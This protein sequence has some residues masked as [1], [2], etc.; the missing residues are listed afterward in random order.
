M[1]KYDSEDKYEQS[2][3]NK[4]GQDGGQFTGNA[5]WIGATWYNGNGQNVG[6]YKPSCWPNCTGQNVGNA[7]GVGATWYNGN[8]QNVGHYKPSCWPNCTGQ[9]VGNAPGVGA[10]WYNGNGQNVGHYKPS[11]WPNCT[12]QN[13]G[14]AP[15]VGATWYNGNGQNVGKSCWLNDD[16]VGNVQWI[17][18]TQHNGNTPW[19]GAPVGSVPWPHGFGPNVGDSASLTGSNC[20]K[21][22]VLGNIPG[23]LICLA[24]GIGSSAAPT[25]TYGNAQQSGCPSCS[26]WYEPS[27]SSGCPSCSGWYEP[28]KSSGCPSCSGWYEPSKSSGCSSCG[29][30]YEPS[31]SSGCSSCGGWYEP[32]KSSGCSSCGGPFKSSWQLPGGNGP[33][34]GASWYPTASNWTGPTGEPQFAPKTNFANNDKEYSLT[35]EVPG[36][37]PKGIKISASNDILTITGERKSVGDPDLKNGGDNDKGYLAKEIPTG[38]FSRSYPIP[39]DADQDLISAKHMDGFLVVTL[40]RK[41]GSIKSVPIKVVK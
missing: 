24:G 16:G 6:H 17:C 1:I 36:A 30:W 38:T 32:S 13:V 10:T 21:Y 22:L 14:N 12:G 11:C 20:Y 3:V 28:S 9:N 7:P 26:G 39:S 40:A 37:D 2:K 18:T 5:P 4:D 15:G 8:G 41:C 27:K 23:Y 34:V 33:N 31:K 25:F 19:T 35:L 29:G